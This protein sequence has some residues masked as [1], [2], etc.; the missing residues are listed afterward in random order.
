MSLKGR[1]HNG[2][3]VMQKSR[4]AAGN[5]LNVSEMFLVFG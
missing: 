2:I 1:K 4:L 5:L 3:A